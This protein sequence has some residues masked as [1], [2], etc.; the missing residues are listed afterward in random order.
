[1]SQIGQLVSLG[2]ALKAL[3]AGAPLAVKKV[4]AP[5]AAESTPPSPPADASVDAIASRWGLFA[6]AMK[7]SNIILGAVLADCRPLTLAG[8]T[9]KIA[10]PEKFNTNF[11]RDKL[12][13]LQD[14]KSAVDA[15]MQKAFGAV[16]KAE[17]EF[18]S[19]GSASA[20]AKSIDMS[21]DPSIKKIVEKFQ[22]IRIIESE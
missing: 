17:F 2:D 22:G 10:I 4:E 21:Q 19:T 9:L 5:V 20:P 8:G 11:H 18:A 3:K 7:E 16:Y 15:A 13:K 12:K 6:D 14:M 1:M